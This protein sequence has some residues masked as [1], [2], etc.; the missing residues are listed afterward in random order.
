MSSQLSDLD[1]QRLQENLLE[2]KT[3]NYTLEDQGRKQ[4]SAL[5]DATARV[6]VLQQ[7]LTKAKKVI[8]KSKKITEVQKILND[9][10]NLQRKLMSQEDDFRLQNQTLLT[11]LTILVTANEKLEKEASKTNSPDTESKNKDQLGYLNQV[12]DLKDK[13]KIY[14]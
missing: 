10:D 2:L 9:N 7:E 6:T 1:F 11:E 8:D 3:R 12:A 5:G 13:L 14:E 4:R